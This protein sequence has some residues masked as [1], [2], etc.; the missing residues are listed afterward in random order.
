[1]SV[2]V[3]SA[4]MSF[5]ANSSVPSFS[6]GSR[7]GIFFPGPS[8]PVSCRYSSQGS[9]V[10]STNVLMPYF[11]Q[12]SATRS[13]TSPSS[14]GDLATFWMNSLYQDVSWHADSLP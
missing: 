14:F 6:Q 11:W 2:P 7:D 5:S 13:A 12:R 4:W 8:T 1:M 3:D 10:C 9:P